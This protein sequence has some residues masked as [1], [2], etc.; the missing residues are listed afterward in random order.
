MRLSNGTQ[1]ER[2]PPPTQPQPPKAAEAEFVI[3]DQT[4]SL[5]CRGA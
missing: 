1:A 3:C 2:K 4:I 5:L